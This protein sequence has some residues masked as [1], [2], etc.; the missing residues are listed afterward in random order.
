MDVKTA[1][2]NGDLQEEVYMTQ[3][4]GFEV[5]GQ[6]H[7]VYK[8]IKAL[9]GLKQAPCAW[10]AKMDE[11]L[12]K[13]GF[14]RSESDDTLYVRQQGKY[15]VILVMYVNDFI[16]TGNHDDHIAQVKKELHAGFKMTD[17][18]LLHYYLGVEVF[19]R[20]HHIFI[21]QSK[22]AAEEPRDSHWN[23]AKRVIRYIPGTKDFGLLY[24]K[25]KIFV[26]GG[27]SDADFAR[28]IDDRASTSGY[29]MNTGSATVSWSCKKQATVATSSAEAEYISPWEATCEIVWLHR[30]LQDL[31]ISQT[32]ATSLFID[33]QSAIKL[34][35]NPVFHSKTKHVDTK[36]HH[37]RYLIAKDVLK[38]VYCPSEDQISD[39]FT[40]PPG[41]IKFTKFWDELGICCN[42]SL[43]HRGEC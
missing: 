17:L 5:E 20:P 2:L 12:K 26:L 8:L 15:L 42:V 31:G 9:Y 39:I 23:A 3:P 28:S 11:Y 24:T 16:I 14:Q 29:L 33:S 32:E 4:P 35:K 36:S 22:Y 1:F 43:D 27:Y 40:K 34:A 18:G 41:R 21:S 19:Q 25:T 6:E 13:V 10:Y 38:P 7:K 37:I 30:I